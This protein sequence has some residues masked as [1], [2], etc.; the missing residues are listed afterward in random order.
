[1]LAVAVHARGD[2]LAAIGARSGVPFL[3]DLAQ[4]DPVTRPTLPPVNAIAWAGRGRTLA[5]ASVAGGLALHRV[6]GITESD[7]H[8]LAA[9]PSPVHITR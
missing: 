8:G 2:L 5:L 3:A 9:R 6:P 7:V 4:P 1:V